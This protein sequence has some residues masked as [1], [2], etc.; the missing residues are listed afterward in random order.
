MGKRKFNIDGEKDDLKERVND[1]EQV[2]MALTTN[3]HPHPEALKARDR[4]KGR[5]E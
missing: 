1:L 2:V 5:L 3:E 4:I